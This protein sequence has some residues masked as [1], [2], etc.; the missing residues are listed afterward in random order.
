MKK[1]DIRKLAAA[2]MLVAVAVI[3]SPLSI[4]VGA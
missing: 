4:P 2:A 1:T 3:C